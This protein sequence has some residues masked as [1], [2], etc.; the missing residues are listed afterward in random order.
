[1]NGLGKKGYWA[2]RLIKPQ[3]KKNC[4][5]LDSPTALQSF[6]LFRLTGTH[7]YLLLTPVLFRLQQESEFIKK[8]FSFEL[9]KSNIIALLQV[10]IYATFIRRT[11]SVVFRCASV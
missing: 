8:T 2:C 1:M 4:L 5:S 7:I 10:L 9:G 6:T 3:R 11:L